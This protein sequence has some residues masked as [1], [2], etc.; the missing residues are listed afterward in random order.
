MNIKACLAISIRGR[1]VVG[2]M[3]D[4]SGWSQHVVH[5]PEF[6]CSQTGAHAW[7]DWTSQ[8]ISAE[9][10]TTINRSQ[11]TL[12]PDA[13]LGNSSADAT[14]RQELGLCGHMCGRFDESPG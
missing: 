2:R 8:F 6:S 13:W 4:H 14:P 12:R 1:D 7:V 3:H 10:L 11:T 5:G 9:E